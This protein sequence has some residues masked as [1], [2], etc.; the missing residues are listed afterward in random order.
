MICCPLSLDSPDRETLMTQDKQGT[1]SVVIMEEE[2]RKLAD[3]CT[4]PRS[5]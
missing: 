4:L 3:S 1:A 2:V 5:D